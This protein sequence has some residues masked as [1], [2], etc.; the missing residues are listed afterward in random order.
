VPTVDG[1]VQLEWHEAGID[2][3]VEVQSAFRFSVYF[4]DSKT[5]E[6]REEEL[7]ADLTPLRDWVALLS[8]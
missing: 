4:V 6:V 8:A 3:E 2:L 7:M 1:G 5:G